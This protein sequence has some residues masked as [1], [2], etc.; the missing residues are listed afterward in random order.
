MNKTTKGAITAGA[1]VVLLV[2]GAGSLAYWSDSESLGGGSVSSGTLTIDPDPASLTGVWADESGTVINGT[3]FDPATQKI[4]P[5][6]VITYSKKFVVGATGKNLKATVVADEPIR[7]AGTLWDSVAPTVTSKI[8]AA[9]VAQITSADD[10]KTVDVKVTLTFDS[11]TPDKVNQAKSINL[12]D[13]DIT[14]TQVR[15]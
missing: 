1:A 6:D 12:S 4:V 3:T 15:P 8:G 7:T 13:L 2:G 10:G 9:P 5:G 14:L 11:T